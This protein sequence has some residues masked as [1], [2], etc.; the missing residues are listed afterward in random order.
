[1]PFSRPTLTTLIDRARAD[2]DSRLPGADSRLRRSALDVLARVHAGGLHGLYGYVDWA[3]RQLMPDTADAEH[4]D[5]WASVWGVARKEAVAAAGEVA[6]TGDNGVEV[7]AGSV[8][9]RGDGA[10]YVTTADVT[11]A[12]GVATAAVEAVTAGAAGD[13]LAGV[14]LTFVSPIAGVSSTATVNAPGL[15]EGLDQEADPALRERLLE[16]IRQQPRGGAANDYV[17]W[18]KEVPEVTRA[19]V[20][21]EKNGL[22]TVG[23]AF[24]MDGRP[25]IIPE[26][27]DVAAV[28]AWI[29]DRRPVTADVETFAPTA[30]PLDLTIELTP[31]STEVRVAVEASLL[32]LLAREAEPGGTILISH[33]RE[34]VSVA[35]GETDHILT[36]PSAN[37]VAAAGDIAVLGTITWV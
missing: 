37:V 17:R 9:Q 21:P 2:L 24:V 29:A 3:A 34:A 14:T 33:I 26:P 36:V 15:S 8:L 30:D 23:V 16:R 22:G 19:W 4:L 32:D 35:A 13:A 11:I 1:M 28:D 18:A 31:D 5:R 27:A 25:V 20:Y 10:D 6:L 12:M 7:P